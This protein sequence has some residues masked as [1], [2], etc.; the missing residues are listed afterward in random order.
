VNIRHIRDDDW[1][2]V[3]V[4]E[5]QAYT[6]AL[7]L[8]EDR[9][10]LVSKYRASPS[11]CFVLEAEQI[12]GYLLSLPYPRFEY[13]A[14]AQTEEVVRQS[15][16][17]HLHDLVIAQRLRGLG[18]ARRMLRELISTARS[19]N[20]RWISLIAV[21]GSESFWRYQ[22]FNPCSE[23]KLPGNYGADAVYMSKAI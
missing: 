7:A 3:V 19:K 4:L 18:W 23:I 14:L 15:R 20:Y 11:T 21:A 10:A 6:G 8:S 5:A 16:N 12:E 17:L 9:S 2:T 22:G 1:D 13:P